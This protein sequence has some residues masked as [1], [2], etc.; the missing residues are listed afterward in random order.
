M[1]L[2][3]L[4]LFCSLLISCNL[5]ENAVKTA[6]SKYEISSFSNQN[7]GNIEII[8][9][10]LFYLP[11]HRTVLSKYITLEQGNNFC[12]ARYIYQT[13]KGVFRIYYVIDMEKE[14]ILESS[15][16]VNAF[17][18]PIYNEYIDIKTDDN[19]LQGTNTV[20]LMQSGY[21]P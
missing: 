20:N 2:I 13:T 4:F 18:K 15:N 17:F 16:D 19:F 11:I 8:C 9:D 1:R 7:L 21:C 6:I 14:S 3:T 12:I 10:D 5:E